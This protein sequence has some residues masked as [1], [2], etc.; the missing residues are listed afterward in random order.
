MR[1]SVYILSF[2]LLLCGCAKQERDNKSDVPLIVEV[3][4]PTVEKELT[5]EKVYES[6]IDKVVL[7][8]ANKDG[9]PYSQGTG[10]FISEDTLLTNYHVVA[11]ASSVKIKFPNQDDFINGVK[12]VKASPENDLAILV[13]KNKFSYIEID[14]VS[15]NKIGGRVFTIGNPRGLEGTI[16]EGILSGYRINDDEEFLQ[17]TAPISPGNSGGPIINKN[18]K[19]IGVATFTFKNSQNL[20]FGIPIKYISRCIPIEDIPVTAKSPRTLNEVGAITVT[21]FQKL[22]SEFEE[23]ISL[24]NNT[25]DVITSV[26]FVVIYKRKNEIIDYKVNSYNVEIEPGLARRFT[27]RSFDQSQDWEYVKERNYAHDCYKHFDIE[28]RILEYQVEE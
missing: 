6:T 12:I 18:G 28:V 21:D 11:G 19:V 13:T 17:I 7:V 9:V 20:N 22:G 5:A 15:D 27:Y 2:M 24:K 4:D 16:S 25:D 10:F 14:S 3:G 8:L 23:H 26:T 1:K